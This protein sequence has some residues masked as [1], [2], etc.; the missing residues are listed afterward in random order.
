MADA[1]RGLTI[2]LGADA[3][4]LNSAISAITRSA[5]QAQ[6]QMNRL[7]KALK[8]D[9]TNAS[10][11]QSK[12]DLMGDKATHSARAFDK[13]KVAMR[14]AR[15]ECQVLAEK[16]G[17]A[18][19]SFDKIAGKTT[20]AYAETHKIRDELFTVDASLQHIYDDAAKVVAKLSGFSNADAIEYIK[21]LRTEM[22]GSGEAAEAAEAELRGYIEE[23]ASLKGVAEKF[24][25]V[26]M[27]GKELVA[28]YDQLR[29]HQK[30]LSN[31]QDLMNAVEGY[32]AMRVHLQAYRAELRQS[33]AETARLKTELYAMG[34][35]G[36]LSRAVA[37]VK[38]LD[39][40]TEKAVANAKQMLDTYRAYPNDLQA[41]VGKNRAIAAASATL[42]AKLE[43]INAALA[44]LRGDPAFDIMA[45]SS[46]KAYIKAVK[47]EQEYTDIDAA[48]K[49]AESRLDRFNKE[50]NNMRDN[51]VDETSDEFKECAENANKAENRVQELKRRLDALRGDHAAAA[52]VTEF[53]ELE[54]QAAA[55]KAQIAALHAQ[56]SKLRALSNLGK[57]MREFG[58]G[59][60][61]SLTPAL[62]MAGRY[63]I[64]AARDVDSAYRDMRKTVNGTEEDFEHL[65]DAAIEFSRTHVTSADTML[66]IEAMG[67]QLGIQVEN[68]E[69]FAH[70]VSNL[71]IATNLDSDTIAEDLGKMAT[72]LGITEDQYDSFAD[73]LVRLGNNM[74]A[75]ESDIM[76]AAMR[77]QGMGKV[78]GLS[79]D[80]VL[81]WATAAVSTGQKAEAAG[82]SM[83]R[84]MSNM[85]TAVN[86]GEDK[87]DAWAN[88]AGMS[89]EEFKQAF[90]TDASSAMYSFIEGLGEMHKNGE[91]VNQQL[92]LLG[93]NNVRDKQLLEG[94]AMQMANATD[95]ANVLADALRLSN[96]AYNGLPSNYKG[97]VEEAG[98]AMREAE[99]KSE[100]FSGELQKM[101][102]NAKALAVELGE[103]AV[104][105]IKEL[106]GML[107]DATGWFRDLPDG[108]KEIAVKAG[109]LLAAIGP[110][111]V[112]FGTFFQIFERF[113]IGAKGIQGVFT[114]LAAKIDVVGPAFTRAEKARRGFASGL[115]ALGTAKGM[116]GA[117]LAIAGVGIAVDAVSKGIQEHIKK[118]EDFKKA[119]QGVLEVTSRSTRV[120]YAD[121]K[122]IGEYGD[123]AKVAAKSVDE[124]VESTGEMVD[125]QN[126]RAESAE[127]DIGQ[128]KMAQQIIDKYAN[129]DL[130]G[131]IAAQ[132]QLRAAV[133]LV[134]EKCGTQYQ[135]LD[136]VNGK[137]A[138]E[139]GQIDGVKDAIYEYIQAKEQ[140][141]R[142]DNLTSKFAEDQAALDAAAAAYTQ[143]I[144]KEKAAIDSYQ[145]ELD[146]SSIT[147]ERRTQIEN[148]LAGLRSDSEKA[149]EIMMSL[150]EATEQDAIALG[151]LADNADASTRTIE[152]MAKASSTLDA[153]LS[154]DELN[155][156]AAGLKESGMTMA[157][158]EDVS[159]EG[160]A[161]AVTA[162]RNS[163]N[164]MG[165]AMQALGLEAR[166][167]SERYQA[168]MQ[169]IQNS[170]DMWDHIVEKTGQTGDDLATA[171]DGAGISAQQLASMGTEAFDALYEA[172]GGDFANIKRELDLL[173]AA[174]I[175]PVDIHVE[176][177]ELRTASDIAIQ[178]D[179]DLANIGEREFHWKGD[180]FEEITGQV[181]QLKQ[182]AEEG[183]E[184][185]VGA[186]T[187]D[188]DA[189]EEQIAEAQEMADAGITVEASVEQNES[190]E[191]FVSLIDELKSIG[192]VGVSTSISVDTS[193]I[194]DASAK[195]ENLRG[196]VSRAMHGKISISENTSAVT[197]KLSALNSY[198]LNPKTVSVSV[199][200]GALSTLYAIEKELRDL[201]GRQSTV[202]VT[203]IK[204]TKSEG[205]ASGAIVP[206]H[207]SGALIPRNA[208]GAINGIV[209][210]A[211][212]TNIGLVGE[213]GAEALFH[214]RNAGGA[215]VPLSNRRYVRPFAHAVA[216]EMSGMYAQAKG[217]SGIVVNMNLAYDASSDASQVAWEIADKLELVLNARGVA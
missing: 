33:A 202:T 137:L 23:A 155:D 123:A 44:K 1:F 184:M 66:E 82:S 67:G 212:M 69:A 28:I 186:D 6:Q 32:R 38:M 85:E 95:D 14:Q 170:T 57:G 119:T 198:K 47:I 31:Q 199:T 187:E 143:A 116:L 29:A 125:K 145:V 205:S 128:L 208:D 56:T 185:E 7:N 43:S 107:K 139:K 39:Q 127:N 122:G 113:A 204:K 13:I 114:N 65:R 48:L 49:A 169:S 93:I 215:V 197:A 157:E 141:I 42:N 46:E 174:G 153:M 211:M 209:T 203:T 156:F 10:L 70:T 17:R 26:E 193:G 45:A 120:L 27:E 136:I 106:G 180:G 151:N 104:P 167:L 61:A 217:G 194:D 68:L 154:T 160:W 77:F 80:Q 16:A 111:S 140:Q 173:D 207:A 92:K 83:I 178:L 9:P 191:N 108:I 213:A 181:D 58:F 131:N 112:G 86:A 5:A 105:A 91:S 142:A 20:N 34:T 81:A 19:E 196:A 210:R 76:N 97:K 96:D 88:V 15:S 40:A 146:S 164:D 192:T 130:S 147:D 118:Q 190:I 158:F 11:M 138:D 84:F 41:A 165:A 216:S 25:R 98:D 179:G 73:S 206:A 166:T 188:L 90:E 36:R 177:G 22:R 133:A 100:G 163:G 50:L 175:K 75:M 37:E 144:E 18:G 87:L 78:V 172:A 115:N 35:G 94:F 129:T 195:W 183:A 2:R 79:A 102:N 150:Q 182:E 148:E 74:P 4:P 71:D 24:G 149:Y 52:L 109:V 117:S 135:I 168:E 103:A 152:T 171:L 176:D 62:M 55:A 8:F 121:A 30:S 99:K 132:G 89:A 21:V 124:L 53:H 101:I 60:Y 161:N 59:M 64:Q 189:A 201:D 162:W 3:R 200:G 134:N 126:E 12:I 51:K 63:A 110:L 54:T 159:V 214:M 72:V